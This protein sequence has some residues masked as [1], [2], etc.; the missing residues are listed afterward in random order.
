MCASKSNTLLRGMRAIFDE[1]E[2]SMQIPTEPNLEK[3]VDKVAGLASV[4]NRDLVDD[5]L[6]AVSWDGDADT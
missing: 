3:L 1:M 2:N 5:V 6:R 4:P